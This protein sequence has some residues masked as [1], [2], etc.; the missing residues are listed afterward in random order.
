MSRP[1][2]S[3]TLWIVGLVFGVL[4]VC[5]STSAQT[6]RWKAHDMERPRPP[7]VT[8]AEQ[9]LPVAPPSDAVVLFDGTNLSEWRDAQGGPARW[10]VVDG[11]MQAG[12]GELFTARGFG[13]VQLHVEWA[14]P[15]PAS[16]RSQGRGNSGVFLMG[17]YEIQVLDCYQNETYADGQAGAIYGQ[18]PPLANASLP[19]GQ[20]Q[21]F[22]IFFRRPRFDADGL[23]V[24]PARATVLHNGVL[25]QEAAELWGPTSWLQHLPYSAHPDKLPISLQDH[26]NPV[27]FRNIWLRELPEYDQPGPPP[28]PQPPV[29]NLPES[30]LQRYVGSYR[31]DFSTNFRIALE[32]GQL[33]AYFYGPGWLKLVPHS[34]S[35]FSMPW[36]AG[37][38]VFDLDEDGTPRGFTFYLGGD[39]TR[40]TRTR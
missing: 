31:R 1:V 5:S 2:F 39:E 37:R 9:A 11:C 35:E 38:V 10:R 3:R 4:G 26:G 22:D 17:L 36:T 40:V 24:R 23:L 30:V 34:A 7:V 28:K 21:T 20:W 29:V 12:G 32:D 15:L 13:D 18:H 27:R 6:P 33:Q 19:P 8:P 14:S 25:I 16:G